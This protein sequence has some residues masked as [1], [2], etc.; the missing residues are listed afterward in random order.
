LIE[1]SPRSRQG[2]LVSIFENDRLAFGFSNGDF[3]AMALKLFFPALPLLLLKQVHSDRI[4]T[5]G[6]WGAGTEDDGLLLDQRGKLAVIQTA[7]CLPLFFYND[8]S[9]CGGVIHIGWRGLQQGIEG[10]LAE[11]LKKTIGSFSFFLGPAIAHNC[12]EV[13]EELVDLFAKKPY[14][15]DIFSKKSR[16]KYSMDLKAGITL[17]LQNLGIAAARIQDS[18]LCTFCSGGRFP[19]Y[20]R[21]GKTGKRIFNFLLLKNG[22]P[23]GN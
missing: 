12:Y 21:D 5:A 11:L 4:V 10:K 3:P 19:S 18:G 23:S 1:L 17:S 13:G 2:H 22:F 7:D 14:A 9:S 16:G 20:R 15:K 6:D 8:D